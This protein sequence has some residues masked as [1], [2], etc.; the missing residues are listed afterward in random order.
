MT[1]E[2]EKTVPVKAGDWV[3]FHGS[4][5]DPVAVILRQ[6]E[7]KTPSLIKFKGGGFP[8]QCNV[9]SV[10][11]AFAD[12]ETAERIKNNIDGVAGEFYRRRRAAE[13]ERSR[14]ITEALTAA[15]QQIQRLIS[16]EE[17]HV[18]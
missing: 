6:A 10:V 1:G 4:S 12:K 2:V 5:Y 8:R 3:L 14:R 17:N 18:G 7:K 11:G 15:N 9:I 13:D 16:A